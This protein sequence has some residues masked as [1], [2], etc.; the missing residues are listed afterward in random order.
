MAKVIYQEEEE[1]GWHGLGSEVSKIYQVLNIED[2]NKYIIEKC[3]ILKAIEKSNKDDMMNQFRNSKKLEDIKKIVT[4]PSSRH[5]LM[6]VILM[7][8]E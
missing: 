8:P 7:M 4:S 5:I 2:L 6:I 1:K 3:D